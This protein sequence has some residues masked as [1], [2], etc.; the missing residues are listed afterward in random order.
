MEVRFR[1][2][3]EDDLS[4]LYDYLAEATHPDSAFEFVWNLRRHCF[5]LADFSERGA[6]RDDVLPGLR[7]LALERRTVIAY[8]VEDHVSILAIFHGGQNWTDEFLESDDKG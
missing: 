4:N 5:S 3:A 6:R 8:L 7:I 1:P 2:R